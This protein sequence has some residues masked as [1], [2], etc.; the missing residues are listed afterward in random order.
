MAVAQRPSRT[1]AFAASM[2]P[3]QTVRKYWT[4]SKR[5]AMKSMVALRKGEREPRPPGTMRT[6]SGGAVSSVCVGTTSW[7]KVEF[8]GFMRGVTGLVVTG[9][10]VS[11]MRA[12]FMLW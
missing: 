8:L 1:P 7:K 2:E 3:V 10:M 4:E 11:A 9:S 5:E 6:S 12:R